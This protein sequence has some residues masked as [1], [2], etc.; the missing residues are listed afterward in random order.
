MNKLR[1]WDIGLKRFRNEYDWTID[2]QT[3]TAHSLHCTE[4]GWLIQN[5]AFYTIERYIG[6]K[7]INDQ[8]IYEGDI[9]RIKD[10]KTG[11]TFTGEVIF[12]NASFCVES[13]IAIHYR[14]IDYQIT[15]LGNKHE[16][17]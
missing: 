11:R 5:E 16:N 14:W 10:N 12:N 17:T 13:D 6:L 8:E 4:D 15:K 2:P 7:D 9:V 1:A 3:G